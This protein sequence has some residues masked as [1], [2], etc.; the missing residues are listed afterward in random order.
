MANEWIAIHDQ[1]PQRSRCIA[2]RSRPLPTVGGDDRISLAIRM[3]GE[4]ARRRHDN[5]RAQ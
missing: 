2:F 4:V 5:H 3:A 1:N